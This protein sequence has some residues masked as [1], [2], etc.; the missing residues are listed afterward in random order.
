MLNIGNHP[1][2]RGGQDRSVDSLKFS[3]PGCGQHI[4]CE[5]TYGGMVIPCPSCS[6]QMQVPVPSVNVTS[7]QVTAPEAG[8]KIEEQS[9]RKNAPSE[10]NTMSGG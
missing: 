2:S 6:A 7:H 9:Y 5:V 8:Q 1:G 10:R 4:E 3:C